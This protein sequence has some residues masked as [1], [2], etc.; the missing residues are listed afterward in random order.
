MKITINLTNKEIER[1]KSQ[2]WACH[3]SGVKPI[4]FV[5]LRKILKA[6]KIAQKAPK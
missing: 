1:V 6:V 3:M 5:A 4:S 2:V